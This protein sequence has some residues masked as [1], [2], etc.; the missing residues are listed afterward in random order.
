MKKN[1]FIIK[2]TDEQKKSL[3]DETIEEL[4]AVDY[5]KKGSYDKSEKAGTHVVLTD[6][7]KKIIEENTKMANHDVEIKWK[8][9]ILGINADDI[10]SIEDV[11]MRGCD[12]WSVPT[13]DLT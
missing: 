8:P 7:Q 12:Y 5:Q 10:S 6:E 2:L 11:T 3:G 13:A 4:V 1:F 9:A